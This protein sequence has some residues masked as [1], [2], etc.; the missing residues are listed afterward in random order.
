MLYIILS[1]CGN[2]FSAIYIGGTNYLT[3]YWQYPQY[4]NYSIAL[5]LII[6]LM[7]MKIKYDK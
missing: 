5:T 3:G 4:F 7:V 2:V 6:I 1:I